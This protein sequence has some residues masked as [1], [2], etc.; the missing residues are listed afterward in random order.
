[1]MPPINAIPPCC[2][3][4]ALDLTPLYPAS[5]FDA[6]DATIFTLARCERCG[7]V[8][9]EPALTEAQLGRY[10]AEDYYGGGRRKFIGIVEWF[11]RLDNQ[12]RAR[13]LLNLLR[14]HTSTNATTAWRILDI[15]C[16]R[17]HLLAALARQGC[18]CYGVER[19]EFPLDHAQAGIHFHRDGL[20]H[21]PL[22]ADSCD[23]IILWH[24]LEHV[25]NP[26]ATLQIAARLLRSGG[27]LALA[28]PNFGSWQAQLFKRAWFHLD[29]PRHTHHFNGPALQQLLKSYGLQLL[30]TSTWAFDQNVYGFIQS[31]LNKLLPPRQANALYA[32][33]KNPRGQGAKMRLLGWLAAAGVIAPLALAEYVLAGLWGRGA[34]LI[35]YAQKQS[36]EPGNKAQ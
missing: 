29:L 17:A 5:A 9:T 35:V 7:L 27:I 26:A 10:Y 3:C 1:M 22:A 30:K 12:R 31:L 11:T 6:T 36:G 4:G 33:L 20:E 34:T 16:G 19:Q 13:R 23:A 18:E 15:G 8:R 14:S 21:L 25:G 28:V 24:V 2:G 32:L